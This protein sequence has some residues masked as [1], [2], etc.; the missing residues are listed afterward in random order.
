M[1]IICSISSTL[2]NID[3]IRLNIQATPDLAMHNIVEV[4]HSMQKKC[5]RWPLH[6]PP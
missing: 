2:D 5:I 1:E 6:C 3:Y 4:A